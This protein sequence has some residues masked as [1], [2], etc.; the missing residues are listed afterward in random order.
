[1]YIIV[2][3]LSDEATI[4]TRATGGSAGYDLYAHSSGEIKAR[5]HGIV[6]TK[7]AMLIPKNNCGLIWP[8]SG[9]S[10]KHGI[11]TGAGVI[12]SDYT[13]EIK[14]ILHNHSDTIFK[15]EQGMRIAQILIQPVTTPELKCESGTSKHAPV[16]DLCDS[17]YHSNIDSNIY[18]SDYE[19]NIPESLNTR[20]SKGF[21]SSGL[22]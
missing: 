9:F 8:R 19:S 20:N 2:K 16:N 4:P 13:G 12:D 5:T 6:D 3:K 17:I 10:A 18:S 14:V 1:M 21:G 22:F 7:I 11:E 15:Y